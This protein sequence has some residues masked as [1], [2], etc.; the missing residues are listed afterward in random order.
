MSDPFDDACEVPVAG[1]TLMVARAGR[2][3]EE[4]DG[5]VLAVHGISASHMAWAS[6]AREL[7]A[8]TGACLL[9]PDLRGRGRSAGIRGPYGMAAHVDDLVAVLDFFGVESAIVAGHSMGAYVAARLAAEHPERVSSLVLVDGGLPI[10]APPDEDPEELLGAIL[11]S[12]LARLGVTFAKR[13]DYLLMWRLHPAFAGPWDDDIEAYLTYDLV[14]AADAARPDAVRS[15]TSGTAVRTD[16]REMLLDEA[17]R[18]ALMDVQAPVRL[19]LAARG[20]LNG[21]PLLPRDAVE[22]FVATHPQTRVEEVGDTNHYNLLLGPG[23]GAGRVTRAIV[24]ALD[25]A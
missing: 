4:A 13:E 22:E 7:A 20:L 9:V 17:T 6:V 8:T 3:V 11:G 15:V 18:S 14:G 12:S 23:H 1:G 5:V 2:P 10:P 24:S 19:L 16:G 21:D 25:E